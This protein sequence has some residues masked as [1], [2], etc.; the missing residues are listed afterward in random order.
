[1][2]ATYE[3]TFGV[4]PGLSQGRTFPLH[5]AGAKELGKEG[6]SLRQL[7]FG[8]MQG[9]VSLGCINIVMAIMTMS[10]FHSR[11]LHRC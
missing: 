10:N 7:L 2:I 1:M 4:N 6:V 11:S 9:A 3:Q 5:S 8:T